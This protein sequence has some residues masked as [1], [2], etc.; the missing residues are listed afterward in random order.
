MRKSCFPSVLCGNIVIADLPRMG[1]RE[2]EE[3]HEWRSK[4]SFNFHF[5]IIA[6]KYIKYSFK[7]MWWWLMMYWSEV[8]NSIHQ[9]KNSPLF[10][11]LISIQ[12]VFN[13][14]ASIHLKFPLLVLYF[15]WLQRASNIWLG[16]ESWRQSKTCWLE[17][18][19]LSLLQIYIFFHVS[20]SNTQK[21]LLYGRE[22]G[23]Y[24]CIHE[25]DL[26][27][28]E[29]QRARIEIYFPRIS[30]ENDLQL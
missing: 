28:I 9:K 6:F 3:L 4:L 15:I 7:Y 13:K 21:R 16:V 1:E 17:N 2:R 10:Q 22:I 12:K 19:I 14:K 5:T 18:S 24:K 8:C 20:E 11:M 23:I 30:F 27:Y 29:C 26:F 25:G